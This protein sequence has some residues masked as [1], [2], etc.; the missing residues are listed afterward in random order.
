MS[1]FFSEAYAAAADGAASAAQAS[2][3]Q[4]V[5][6]LV[7]FVLIFYFLLWR[8]QMKR[9]KEHREL[10]SSLEK[11]D[12][13]VTSGGLLGKVEK[14]DDDFL[15]VSIADGVNIKLQR[16]SV[17]STLPKGTIKSI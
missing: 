17:S 8:P 10:V 6:M 3:L 4:P 5:I 11:G 2:P 15:V 16:G 14:V 7:G 9:T 12:E 13:V 1:L